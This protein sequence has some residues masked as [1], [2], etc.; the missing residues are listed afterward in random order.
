MI[1]SA[2]FARSNSSQSA[3]FDALTALDLDA[4]PLSAIQD[5]AGA[6]NRTLDCDTNDEAACRNALFERIFGSD[7]IFA[8]AID[9]RWAEDHAKISRYVERIDTV[10][11][12]LAVVGDTADRFF[13]AALLLH[14]GVAV[15]LFCCSRHDALGIDVSDMNAYPGDQYELLAKKTKHAHVLEKMRI[16]FGESQNGSVSLGFTDLQ[17]VFHEAVST[18]PKL[19]SERDAE[20]MKTACEEGEKAPRFRLRHF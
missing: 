2:H 6:L 20:V 1:A 18:F 14:A 11:D 3:N 16:L 12:S 7:S 9:F 5:L 8:H 10:D 13:K 17:A 4:L 19:A 15:E